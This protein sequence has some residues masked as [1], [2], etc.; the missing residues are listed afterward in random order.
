MERSLEIFIKQQNNVNSGDDRS[1][2]PEYVGIEGNLIELP[3]TIE[4]SDKPSIIVDLFVMVDG[5]DSDEG[6][7]TFYV[8]CNNS[9]MKIIQNRCDIRLVIPFNYS[10][11]DRLGTVSFFHNIDTELVVNIMVHQAAHEYSV[12]ITDEEDLTI[13]ED[14]VKKINLSSLDKNR[15]KF[16]VECTGGKNDFRIRKPKKF[17]ID[18]ENDFTLPVTYDNAFEL[19]KFK[20]EDRVG[21]ELINHGNINC[22]YELEEPGREETPVQMKELVVDDY[23]Y[24]VTINHINDVDTIDSLKIMYSNTGTDIPEIPIPKARLNAGNQSETVP[25]YIE[26][27]ES[28]NEEEFEPSM[29]CDKVSLHFGPT[30]ETQTIIVETIPED[31]AIFFKKSGT[32]ID[33]AVVDGHEI[34]ITVKDNP[35]RAD[36]TC[37]CYIINAEYNELS[38]PITIKQD[39][40]ST[41]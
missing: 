15:L 37:L 30:R 28:E 26:P 11:D 34:R 27:T 36:R 24:V 5:N 2:S 18:K 17:R 19:V 39:G 20:E 33:K 10:T 3:S 1:L 13:Q 16:Y 40:T 8:V 23:F 12:D 7:N 14:D 35:F 21:F 41:R 9:W 6:N 38:I 22:V 32:F 31:S 4:D 29:T 25:N